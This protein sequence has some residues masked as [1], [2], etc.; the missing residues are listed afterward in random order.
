MPPT[1]Q[2]TQP[3]PAPLPYILRVRD[4]LK[5]HEPEVWAAV[6]DDNA[7]VQDFEAIRLDLLKR[8]YRL[9]PEAE[10]D[11]YAMARDVAEH[12][13][14]APKITLYQHGGADTNAMLFYITG[15]AHIVFYGPI[16][17]QLGP[18]ELRGVLAHELGHYR[19]YEID[20]R[21][22]YVAK[23]ILAGATQHATATPPH[24]ITDA[25]YRRAME[26]YAD[27]CAL[28]ACGD[29]E[30]V[31]S[32]LLKVHVGLDKVNVASY[33]KQAEEVLAADAKGAS[34]IDHPEMFIR[35]RALALWRDDPEGCEAEIQRMLEDTPALEKL[36]LPQQFELAE[37]T[38]RFLSALLEPDWLRTDAVLGQIRMA[39]PEFA[40]G[41]VAM[42]DVLEN[43]NAAP[44]EFSDYFH[45]L[46]LDVATADPDLD[47]APMAWVLT[48]ADQAGRLEDFEKL[49]RKELKRTK[50]ALMA[51]HKKAGKLLAD[52][53]AQHAKGGDRDRDD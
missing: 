45:Y 20:G 19:L 41:T 10:A 21:E 27:R 16:L 29:L 1:T 6:A 42:D 23:R 3:L 13:G 4:L 26:L 40:P 32:G 5:T 2:E 39:I 52:A 22:H 35:A 33:L 30:P 31:V 49:A 17:K 48:V 18:E 25:R 53:A 11:H 24:F 47:D 51:I 44:P 7:S 14:I 38:G 28:A 36:D 37:T 12:L 8:A 9:S 50:K 46:L 34:H 15:E 43:I